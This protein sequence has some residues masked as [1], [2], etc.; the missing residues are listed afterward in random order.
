MKMCHQNSEQEREEGIPILLSE[1]NRQRRRKLNVL[2]LGSGC[3][4][5]GMALSIN[6][7][8]MIEVM[9]MTE[10][11]VGGALDWLR[12]NVEINKKKGNHSF[13]NLKTCPCDWNQYITLTKYKNEDLKIEEFQSNSFM[14]ESHMD[15]SLL[16]T[17]W[18]MII[19]SDLVY[20]EAGVYMLPQVMKIL[21]NSKTQ[22]FYAHT[23]KRYEMIDIDFF[24]ELRKNGFRVEE[25]RERG[26]ETPPDSPPPLSECFPPMRIAVFHMVL[27]T[28]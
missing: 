26:M 21:S 7:E 28:T 18:D 2:E 15:L 23:K 20:D 17:R 8:N 1:T 27:S 13:S 16:E 3:G 9:C 25:C 24:E 4:W 10:Q 19:G 6:L 12:H 22:I 14:N 11:V 5:L